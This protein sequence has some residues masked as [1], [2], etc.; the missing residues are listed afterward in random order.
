MSRSPVVMCCLVGLVFLGCGRAQYESETSAVA[1]FKS[2]V[3]SRNPNLLKQSLSSE[4]RSAASAISESELLAQ[5]EPQRTGLISQFGESAI[6]QQ[7]FEVVS[8]RR[9]SNGTLE[10]RV[11]WRGTELP[12]PLYFVEENGSF[13]FAGAL[14]SPTAAETAATGVEGIWAHWKFRNNLEYSQCTPGADPQLCTLANTDHFTCGINVKTPH[15]VV[16]GQVVS[17]RPC[18]GR[19]CTF[20]G[21]TCTPI[22]ANRGPAGST[23]N[24]IPKQGTGSTSAVE[25]LYQVFGDDAWMQQDPP[26]NY[27]GLP[28]YKWNCSTF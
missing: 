16:R 15:N 17:S 11:A 25:C 13:Y 26:L 22:N 2:A 24:A 19:T 21:S 5:F 1:R 18:D 6:A 20:Y 4:L 3:L 10:F 14:R 27:G 9:Y 23:P 8:S 12:R 7:D 28:I